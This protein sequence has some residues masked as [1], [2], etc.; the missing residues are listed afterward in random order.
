M[1]D[2]ARTEGSDHP[3][4]PLSAEELAAVVAVIREDGGFGDAPIFHTVTLYE[5]HKRD[6]LGWSPGAALAREAFCILMVDGQTWEAV[7]SLDTAS[8]TRREHKA[9]VQPGILLE[10]FVDCEKAV[11]ADPAWQAALKKRGITDF[12][13]AIVDPWSA[14][15]YGDERWPD[16][17]LARAYTWLRGSDD[18]VGYGRPVDGV[19]AVVDLERMAVLEVE[20]HGE[21]EL[22]PLTGNYTADSVG[23]L[24]DD[25]KA[26][27]IV[28]PDGP[29]FHVD[30]QHVEWLGW[31]FRVGF[32]PREG[33][34]LHQ[35]AYNDQGRERPVM[36]RAALSEMVVPYGDPTPV[37]NR[38]NAFDVGEYGV[39]RLANTLTLGCDCLGTIHYFDVDQVTATGEVV[40]MNRV[41]CLHEEDHGT[42]WKHTDWRTEHS[43][44]RRSRRLVISF[45]ATVGNYDYG[46]YWSLYQDG[47]V[48]MDIK[49]TGCLSVGAFP[50]DETPQYGTLVAPQL[51]A[52]IHQHF[53]NFR[54][55]MTVDGVDN[56]VHEIDTVAAPHDAAVNPHLNAYHPVSTLIANERDGAR[57]ADPLAGRQWKIVN[58]SVTN[59]LGQAVGYALVPGETVRPFAYPDAPV[60]R[61][62]AF[63]HH[64]V[65][66]TAYDR[67]ELFAAGDYI[68]Q[69]PADTGLTA[70]ARRQRNLD[71]TDIVLWHTVGHHHIPR[72]EDWPVMP[73]AHAGFT[74]RASGFFDSNPTMN[75]PPSAS[76]HSRHAGCCNEPSST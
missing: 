44:V 19:H 24:R 73:V 75:V 72:P 16:R 69:N 25:I 46:F 37:H 68:N 20:D 56:S 11:K 52:P 34:V 1:D 70:C 54:L 45:F 50:P 23:P 36:Y 38:K 71:D 58:P 9:G 28:Q 41:I 35:L 33:L 14:G 61:R 26:L 39:G 18:D 32:T 29:S 30:G 5:P 63:I 47:T 55:D 22:P 12:D 17:R 74:L 65:W 76:S 66:I 10:E 7:V 8:V 48:E 40:H 51:Y 2:I 60:S 42:L 62:A 64:P 43:E 27:E 59:A 13:R 49:L 21:V 67:D 31:S 4:T 3:L 57:Q 15:F 6:V 53:F